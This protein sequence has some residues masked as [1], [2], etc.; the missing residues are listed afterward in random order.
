M[1]QDSGVKM[2][3]WG[4]IVDKSLKKQIALYLLGLWGWVCLLLDPY[5]PSG[6]DERLTLDSLRALL[7][8]T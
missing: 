4:R 1:F 8:V 6:F 5:T 3:V 2:P 7:T